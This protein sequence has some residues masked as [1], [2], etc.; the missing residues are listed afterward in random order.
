MY[1]LKFG[2]LLSIVMLSVGPQDLVFPETESLYIHF[3]PKLFMV[4]K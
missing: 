2:L 4:G 1:L 3:G